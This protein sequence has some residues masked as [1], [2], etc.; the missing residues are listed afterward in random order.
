[1]PNFIWLGILYAVIRGHRK[2]Y[3]VYIF[4]RF[5]D[6]IHS[7]INAMLDQA[8]DPEKMIRLIIQ[9]MEE[10][11]IE[12]KASC[13]A[14][15]A[16]RKTADRNLQARRQQAAE[17]EKRARLAIEKGR[18]DLAREALIQKHQAL[19][20]S[21][22]AESEIAQLEEIISKYRNEICQLEERLTGAR[23]KQ[24]VLTQ[25]HLQARQRTKV[26]QQIRMADSHLAIAR[27]ERF[28]QQI[29]RMEA[30][31][32]VVNYGKQTRLEEQFVNLERSEQIEAELNDLRNKV[33][34]QPAST[35]P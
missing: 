15:M 14:T 16:A 4:T 3:N 31:A 28:E 20:G 10:T 24:R 11:E 18:E 2:E 33:Q 7:N 22:A 32:D 26:Q 34:K 13:A 23:E 6:I 8:E 9:E 1:L 27:L 21:A 19:E 35:R 5:R 30:E 12:I 25:R 29:D 17:W